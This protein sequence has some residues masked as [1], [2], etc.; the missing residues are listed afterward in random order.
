MLE[1]ILIITL[2]KRSLGRSLPLR[3]TLRGCI[4]SELS[5]YPGCTWDWDKIMSS[6]GVPIVAQQKWTQLESMRMQVQSLAS[7]SGLRTWL[8][9][10]QWCKSQMWLGSCVAV[11][12]IRPLGWEFPY[13]APAVLKKIIIII[14]KRLWLLFLLADYTINPKDIKVHFQT[15]GRS[16]S[17]H[18]YFVI[19]SFPDFAQIFAVWVGVTAYQSTQN[20]FH[21]HAIIQPVSKLQSNKVLWTLHI[22]EKPLFKAN[23]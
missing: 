9:Y 21:L 12:P 13:A 10:E 6:V 14:F 2:I 7:L 17:L 1:V 18:C 15:P 23:I 20:S 8:C 16:I 4:L 22:K 19:F 3:R 11:A 5:G